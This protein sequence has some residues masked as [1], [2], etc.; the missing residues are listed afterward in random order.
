MVYNKLQKLRDNIEAVRVVLT[1]R[2]E[3][4][5]ATEEEKTV[6]S[7]YSGF[8][9]LKFILN[10]SGHDDDIMNWKASDRSYFSDT[11]HLYAI[12]RELSADSI[13]EQEIISSV[14]RSVTTA[15]YTPMPVIEAIAA[16]LHDAHISVRTMLDPSAGIGKFGD[17]FKENN[18]RLQVTSFEKDLLT[19]YILQALHPDDSVVV[20]GFETIDS[21][22]KG[23]FDLVV[24]NIPFGDISV[25]DPEFS[26]SDSEVRRVAASAIHNYFFLKALDMVR[27]GGLVAFITSRGVMDSHRHAAIRYEMVSK[28]NL[29]TAFRLPDGLFS[30]EAGT[31]V[32][33]DLIVLQKDSRKNLLSALE[34]DFVVSEMT[35]DDVFM[36][37]YFSNSREKILCTDAVLG[38]DPYGKPAYVY[39]W[40]DSMEN[41][42]ETLASRLQSDVEL[43]QADIYYDN[44]APKE[45]SVK[46]EKPVSQQVQ[47]GPV[48]LD[49]FA[50]WDA[51]TDSEAEEKPS[52][53]PRQYEGSVPSFYRDGMLAD[54]GMLVGY[55][56]RNCTIF[57]PVDLPADKTE[58]LRQYIL[59]RDSY[60]LLY[61]T[62]AETR[63]E[64]PGLR[65]S[66]NRH[67]DNFVIRYGRLNERKNVEVILMDGMGRDVLSIENARDRQFEKSD[68]F[69]RPVSFVVFDT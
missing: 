41:L 57:T 45:E 26:Q 34:E 46:V 54:D 52:L 36:S 51:D 38:T 8:G 25:F 9:G 67:Y 64:Q 69:V 3:G 11:R 6:L 21:R 14:K 7:K 12:I 23:H 19:G 16:G 20:N 50:M 33:S 65:E 63:A 31:D 68:V 59:I 1:L 53:E 43:M 22:E 4:R 60:N 61:N 39:S 55:L 17:V 5:A 15:F 35:Q 28:A 49:L 10:P 37:H 40:N 29:V 58:R 32:G 48:Q 42:A 44:T 47:S 13:E 62:E 27:E 24:S 2:K 66:L 30:E 56:S 18:D